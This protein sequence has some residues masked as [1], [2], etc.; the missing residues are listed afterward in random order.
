MNDADLKIKYV[1]SAFMCHKASSSDGGMDSK[2]YVY[3]NFRNKFY[4]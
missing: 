3:Y 2:V 4:L 1:P